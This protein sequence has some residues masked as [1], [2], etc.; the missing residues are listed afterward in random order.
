MYCPKCGTQNV[1]DAEYCSNC[2]TNIRTAASVAPQPTS[3]AASEPDIPNR[4][5]SRWLRF[6]AKF[7]DLFIFIGILYAVAI[8]MT[9][10]SVGSILFLALPP[11]LVLQVVWLSTRGQTIGK[12]MVGIKLIS[13]KTGE[14]LGFG[15]NVVIRAWLTTVL[16]IIPFLGLIDILLIFREDKRCIHDL[17]AGTSVVNA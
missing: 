13:T 4:L 15:A 1:D 2:G 10:A 16:G 3:Q 12:R 5:A 14:N 17:M 11:I 6:V 9:V 7:V 8:V